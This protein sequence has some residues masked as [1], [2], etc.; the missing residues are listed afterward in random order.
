MLEVSPSQKDPL[1][2]GVFKLI[3][4][5]WLPAGIVFKNSVG[6]SGLGT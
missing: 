2:T 3:C 5:N 6:V 1:T 4:A